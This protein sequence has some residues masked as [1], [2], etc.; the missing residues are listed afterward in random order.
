V[1]DPDWERRLADTW[2][3]DDLPED[4]LRA[5][6]AALT[7]E[8]PAGDP[9]AAYE[10]GGAW[11]ST[12]HP[13]R[14]IP[15]YREAL[16]AGLPDPYRRQCVVQLASSLRNL[17]EVGDSIALLSAEVA[18]HSDQLDDAVRA[19]LALAL[20]DAGREREGLSLVLTAL[21]PHLP[22]YTRSVT[23]YAKLLLAP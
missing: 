14:A 22:R 13:D 18:D 17:G 19:F 15:L 9:R 5:A 23:N 6:I 3:A 8:L 1:T 11:D 10:R 7:A 21:A 4:D 16:A 20:A 2:A 12:G